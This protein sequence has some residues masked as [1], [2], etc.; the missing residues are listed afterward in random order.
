M[1][2]GGCALA[3]IGCVAAGEEGEE[4]AVVEDGEHDVALASG[5]LDGTGIT[6]CEARAIVALVND[7]STSEG[8]LRALGI[9]S[10]AARGLVSRRPFA[11]LVAVDGV[12]YVGPATLGRLR[13]AV[14]GRCDAPA[15]EAVDPA[16][17][18][19]LEAVVSEAIAATEEEIAALEEEIAK[20]EADHARKAA[21]VDAIAARITEREAEL[22]REYDD[23]RERARTC[24]ILWIIGVPC[25][26]WI[27]SL[28]LVQYFDNDGRRQELLREKAAVEAQQAR[29]RAELA[30]YRARRDARRSDLSVLREAE[31]RIRDLLQ[32]D[33]SDVAVPPVLMM[34]RETVVRAERLRTLEALLENLRD[35]R[36]VLD[37]IRRLAVAANE[38]LDSALVRSRAAEERTI[39]LVE[40]ARES[41]HRMLK[42]AMSADPA[43]EAQAWLEE[44][45]ARRTAEA[46]DGLGYSRGTFVRWLVDHFV[47]GTEIDPDELHDRILEEMGGGAVADVL[48][49]Q[50]RERVDIPDDAPAGAAIAWDVTGEATV[51]RVEV[52]LDIRHTYRG[53]LRVTLEH[54]GRSAVLHDR[55]GGSADD[56]TGTFTTGA[57]AGTA[58]A[59]EW[60]L[61]VVDAAAADT[62]HVAAATVRITYE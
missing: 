19:E 4:V 14:E 37:D 21:E 46:L 2:L 60:R 44:S 47:S 16:L 62:G 27:L 10:R 22:Q 6:E 18:A 39:R 42:I 61:H 12:P 25:P 33:L 31:R 23:L 34:S 35:Q 3:L 41:F 58:I 43:A 49:L 9:A 57:L 48:T 32:R 7:P 26:S 36:D 20:L 51:G 38:S 8:S 55:L 15:V 56:L 29:I 1:A 11:D 17:R 53:D 30:D 54:G 40:E 24:A 13:G 28:T 45:L 5:K 52:V 50:H 59:G